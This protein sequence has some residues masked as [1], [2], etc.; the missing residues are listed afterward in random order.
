M[1]HFA[2][3]SDANISKTVTSRSICFKII[4]AAFADQARHHQGVGRLALTS[5]DAAG[6]KT[7]GPSPEAIVN[8][9]ILPQP[10]C[11]DLAGNRPRSESTLKYRAKHDPSRH[12]KPFLSSSTT[13]SASSAQGWRKGGEGWRPAP[14]CRNPAA[15][16]RHRL[17][18]T[19]PRRMREVTSLPQQQPFGNLQHATSPEIAGH[20]TPVLRPT[21]TRQ[22]APLR[23]PPGIAVSPARRNA[24]RISPCRSDSLR[25]HKQNRAVAGQRSTVTSEQL[26]PRRCR[27]RNPRPVHC[28]RPGSGLPCDCNCRDRDRGSPACPA[29]GTARPGPS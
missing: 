23:R 10:V 2:G 21:D 7:P 17:N 4:G 11:S 16:P 6:R 19:R 1:F 20:P 8:A 15:V 25:C 24:K 9:P 5:P 27:N 28:T 22:P 13:A 3:N 18:D 12:G 14:G 29:S 26:R